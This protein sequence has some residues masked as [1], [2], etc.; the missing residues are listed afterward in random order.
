MSG[1]ALILGIDFGVLSCSLRLICRLS[2]L[3]N[4]VLD[5]EHQKSIW[6]MGKELL[7]TQLFFSKNVV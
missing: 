7:T 1:S 5:Y 2:S 4:V 6:K 3:V